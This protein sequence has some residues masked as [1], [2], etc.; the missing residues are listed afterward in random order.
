[1][2]TIIIATSIATLRRN[3]GMVILVGIAARLVTTAKPIATSAEIYNARFVPESTTANNV[4]GVNA[5]P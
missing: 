2:H 5:Q 1:M 4:I 3:A